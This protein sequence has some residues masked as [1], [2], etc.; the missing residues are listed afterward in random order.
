VRNL[1]GEY[2]RYIKDLNVEPIYDDE[3]LRAVK[4]KRDN[5]LILGASHG[6]GLEIAKLTYD[7]GAHNIK[8]ARSY[9]NGEVARKTYFHCDLGGLD[10]TLSLIKRLRDSQLHIDRFFWVAGRHLKGPFAENDPTQIK[11]TL[12][13][14][15]GNSVLIAQEV[16]RQMLDQG[17][18]SFTVIASTSGIRPRPEEAI[19]AATKWAQVGFTRSLAGE[20]GDA[21]VRLSLFEPGGM[22]TDF[23][24]NE[25]FPPDYETFLDPDKVAVEIVRDVL[26][27][28]D[29]FYEREIPR[30]SL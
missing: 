1:T 3:E 8:V 30:G 21:E 2:K 22:K 23:Y 15:F 13:V 18:K 16:W 6:L 26:N 10:S 4:M 28:K 11:N 20:I 9:Q 29:P 5:I 24:N 19:Y 17:G 27:Q 7:A 14:N 12:D 25:E